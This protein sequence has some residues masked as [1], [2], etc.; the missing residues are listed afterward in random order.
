MCACRLLA[1][2]GF[3]TGRPGAGDRRLA[4]RPR[5]SIGRTDSSQTLRWRKVDSN[6]R[7]S[8]RGGFSWRAASLYIPP[9]RNEARRKT[10][11]L[12][13]LSPAQQSTPWSRFDFDRRRF[14]ALF[15][16]L[17]ALPGQL[18]DPPA[19]HGVFSHRETK[20]SNPACSSREATAN[21]TYGLTKQRTRYD[22][23]EFS[24]IP[25]ERDFKCSEIVA[26]SDFIPSPLGPETWRMN[27]PSLRA[28]SS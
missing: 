14:A 22:D 28:N 6:S 2:L 12:T 3:T 8:V 10:S 18:K 26:G 9:A 1:A 21:L 24:A 27:S 16:L 19:R 23:L 7:F 15:E 5:V 13:G 11:R 25:P 17:R 4:R 20:S